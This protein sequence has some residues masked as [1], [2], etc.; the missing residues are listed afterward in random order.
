VN[1]KAWFVPILAPKDKSLTWTLTWIVLG[2]ISSY[3]VITYLIGLLSRP[4]IWKM[5]SESIEIL[6]H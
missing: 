4:E 3:A 2:G 1:R 5:I 6:K